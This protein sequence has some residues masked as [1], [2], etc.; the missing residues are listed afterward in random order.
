MDS[1]MGSEKN[2]IEQKGKASGGKGGAE[3]KRKR[4][5]G[6]ILEKGK[7]VSDDRKG[8][9]REERWEGVV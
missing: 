6:N 9:G 4:D 1:G 7:W 3:W 5:G 2:K 8:R